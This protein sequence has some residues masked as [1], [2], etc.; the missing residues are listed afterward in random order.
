MCKLTA[1]VSEVISDMKY[2]TIKCLTETGRSIFFP[3][4][5]ISHYALIDNLGSD[6]Y[7]VV[8]SKLFLEEQEDGRFFPD[9]EKYELRRPLSRKKARKRHMSV[10]S[11]R[12]NL[13]SYC[14]PLPLSELWK[15]LYDSIHDMSQDIIQDAFAARDLPE[16]G[17]REA[18]CRI[19]NRDEGL[20]IPVQESRE[21]EFKSSFCH[22]PQHTKKER[23]EQYHSIFNT[24][25]AFAN[26]ESRQGRVYVGVEDK[27]QTLDLTN[28]MLCDMEFNTRNDF[29]TD[30]LN[31]LRTYTDDLALTQSV[32]FTWAEDEKNKLFCVLTL[33][34][35]HG[36][37]VYAG[38]SKDVYVR[39]G[40]SNKKLTGPP[41]EHYIITR[42][43]ND[44]DSL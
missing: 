2:P 12:E 28:E 1:I 26:S 40:S 38:P 9:S 11:L 37:I 19:L 6:G 35:Y 4:H 23:I 8:G 5:C 14:Q 7:P 15:C 17:Q 44:F 21:V 34:P 27:G 29:E 16:D 42:F 24:I 30:F 10:E 36:K 18:L 25:C 33:P 39:H 22:S 32:K 41:L 3:W 13:V 20:S 31:I 43:R